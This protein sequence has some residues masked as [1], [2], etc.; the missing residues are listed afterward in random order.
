MAMSPLGLMD[1]ASPVLRIAHLYP[2]QMNL[3]GDRGNVLTLVKRVQWRG[4]QIELRTLDIGDTP[5]PDWA[6][7]Y[8]MGGGQDRQ[9]LWVTEDLHRLKAN[10]LKQAAAQHAVF[11]GICGG[12]QL[13]GHYYKPHQG[14]ELRGLSLMDAHT[15][16]GHNRLIGDVCI[17]R[18]QKTLVGF[19]NH[20]GLTYLGP[21]VNPLGTIITGN[22]NNGEDKTEGGVYNTIYGTYLHGALLPKNPTFADELITQALARRYGALTL[23]PLD[24]TLENAA[25]Q[26]VMA[27]K[28]GQR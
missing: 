9:Q 26:H 15:I 2:K 8:M 21:S 17:Q 6:D 10:A 5:D 14:D 13:F 16:A 27:E 7:L 12:Y 3:Y 4:W 20:S 23:P 1:D 25:H 24:D 18:G 19:E 11:L 28:A 22:G